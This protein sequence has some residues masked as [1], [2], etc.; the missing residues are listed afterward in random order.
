[1]PSVQSVSPALLRG[2]APGGGVAAAT[3]FALSLAAAAIPLGLAADLDPKTVIVAD[4]A[5]SGSF[6]RSTP[7]FIPTSCS[8]TPTATKSRSILGF[9]YMANAGGWRLNATRFIPQVAR[10]SLRS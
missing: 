10:K 5:V 7:R 6:L 8:T 3:A 4:L 1:M 9:Y 2:H